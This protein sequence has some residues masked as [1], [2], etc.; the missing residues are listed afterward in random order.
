[1]GV[2][3]AD[4]NVFGGADEIAV[5]STVHRLA[6]DVDGF[7]GMLGRAGKGIDIALF[8]AFTASIFIAIGMLAANQDITFAAAIGFVIGAVGNGAV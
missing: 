3:S 2:A 7:A 6:I 5:I 8:K 1:M 4:I